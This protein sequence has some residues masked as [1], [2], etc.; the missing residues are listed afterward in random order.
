M[1]EYFLILYVYAVVHHGVAL[2]VSVKA[3]PNLDTCHRV[4]VATQSM[5]DSY[6]VEV[7]FECVKKGKLGTG[8]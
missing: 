1:G 8:G 4:G 3:M 2:D 6:Y 5:D 7:S